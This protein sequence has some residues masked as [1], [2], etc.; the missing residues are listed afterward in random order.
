[1]TSSFG[2]DTT[3]SVKTTA[4]TTYEATTTGTASDVK[5]GLCVD[6]IG[7][8]DVSGVLDARSVSI[9]SPV[10]GT[11]PVARQLTGGFG[12]GG[13]GSAGGFPGGTGGA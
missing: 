8:D 10:N 5:Q 11:C 3:I 1:V 9:S 2:S 7:S 12:R 6:A 13:F 4:S